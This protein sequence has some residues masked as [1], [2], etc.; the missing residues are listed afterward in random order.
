[1]PLLLKSADRHLHQNMADLHA[2]KQNT[3]LDAVDVQSMSGRKRVAASVLI[4]LYMLWVDCAI[5]CLK[6]PS[7]QATLVLLI[8]RSH[9]CRSPALQ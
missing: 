2:A 6:S 5:Q 1:M 7:L 8:A 3:S 4:G 9:E